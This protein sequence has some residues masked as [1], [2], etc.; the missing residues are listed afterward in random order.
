MITRYFAVWADGDY[1][2]ITRC[3]AVETGTIQ[4]ALVFTWLKA[5]GNLGENRAWFL[6]G[7]NQFEG[8]FALLLATFPPRRIP[9]GNFQVMDH[10]YLEITRPK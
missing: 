7:K 4:D 10:S 2:V 3:F 1:Q 9:P 6:P 8:D 5:S